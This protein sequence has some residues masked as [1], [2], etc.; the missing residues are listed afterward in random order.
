VLQFDPPLMLS[1]ERGSSLLFLPQRGEE[2]GGGVAQL[3]ALR[4]IADVVPEA[5]QRAFDGRPEDRGVQGLITK[6]R[7]RPAPFLT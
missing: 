4:M 1:F 3:A 6:D 2:G 5:L 7:V